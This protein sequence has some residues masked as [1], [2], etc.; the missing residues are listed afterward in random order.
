[1]KLYGNNCDISSVLRVT[2]LLSTISYSWNSIS[3]SL[4]SSYIFISNL[5]RMLYILLFK[6]NSLDR[7]LMPPT[8]LAFYARRNLFSRKRTLSNNNS[9]AYKNS[10]SCKVR[11]LLNSKREITEVEK[12]VTLTK[13]IKQET[14]M[15]MTVMSIR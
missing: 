7:L 5:F 11:V 8:T 1:M 4:L 3:V 2:T 15:S 12:I 9:N 13:Q 10:S 14:R 6:Q